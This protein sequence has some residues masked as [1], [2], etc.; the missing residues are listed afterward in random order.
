ML[1]VLTYHATLLV[2]SAC[3]ETVQCRIEMNLDAM[4]IGGEFSSWGIFNSHI[5]RLTGS[6]PPPSL[7][8]EVKGRLDFWRQLAGTAAGHIMLKMATDT[9]VDSER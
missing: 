3:T 4:L 6:P 2:D 8:F 7:F 5:N 1:E 9:S